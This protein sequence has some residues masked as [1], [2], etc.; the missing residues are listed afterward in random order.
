MVFRSKEYP[1]QKQSSKTSST[2]GTGPFPNQRPLSKFVD[3]IHAEKELIS[4]ISVVVS[5]PIPRVIEAK[6]RTEHN[7]GPD[8][9]GE[10]KRIFRILPG[11]AGTLPFLIVEQIGPE[12]EHKF[13]CDFTIYVVNDRVL[14]SCAA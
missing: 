5:L 8:V 9:S 6:F 10:I 13:G 14:G 12:S 7:R 4:G 1:A 11:D 3:H 2:C